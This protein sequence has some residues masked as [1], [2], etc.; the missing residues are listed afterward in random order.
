[1]I[2]PYCK[3]E[4]EWCENKEIYGRNYGKS[5]M[6]YL[7]RKCNARVGCH[8]N[9]K[10]PLGTMAN[11]KLRKKRMKTHKMVD[12]LWKSGVYKRR[13]VYKMLDE[14]FGESVHI[15]ESNLVRCDEII[16]AIMKGL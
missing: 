14:K 8:N 1:M 7:C 15:G 6:I 2:C 3:Q 10:T 5:Y 4:A 9:T 13:D 12:I 16:K 11:A